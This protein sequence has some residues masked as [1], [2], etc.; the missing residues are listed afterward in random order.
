MSGGNIL[1]VDD[2]PMVLKALERTFLF[3]NF[4]VST[5][6]SGAEALALMSK[7]KI[8]L[9]C[10]DVRMK[11]MDGMDL[12]SEISA[13]YPGTIRVVLSA[14]G[15]KTTMV[16]MVSTGV[17]QLYIMKPWDNEGLVAIIS[18]L[19]ELYSFLRS[20]SM[21]AIMES[22][23]SVQVFPETYRLFLRFINEEKPVADIAKIFEG[24]PDLTARILHLVNSSLY[25]ISISDMKQAL[26]YLGLDTVK[27]L[28]LISEVIRSVPANFAHVNALKMLVKHTHITNTA[29]SV[30][31]KRIFGRKVPESFAVAGILVDI[32]RMIMLKVYGTKYEELLLNSAKTG[33]EFLMSEEKKVFGFNHA[34]AGSRLLDWWMLPAHIVEA[35]RFRYTP[36]QAGIMSQDVMA[37]ISLADSFAWRQAEGFDMELSPELPSH[38]KNDIESLNEILETSK[39]TIL[40]NSSD[41]ILK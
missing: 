10:A 11:P 40:E 16:K 24:Q 28:V 1:F 6:S 30:L 29:L 3:T 32:G 41:G 7:I 9:I 14:L 34:E 18:H 31:Y 2:D 15:D 37:M 23:G 17:A 19:I 36:S 12:M 20:P 39:E 13:I 5:A 38:L 27:N 21:S 22:A 35:A 25:G 33:P 4:S 8:D 26:V